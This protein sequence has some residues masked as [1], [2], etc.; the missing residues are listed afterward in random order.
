M[1]SDANFFWVTLYIVHGAARHSTALL[2]HEEI[3][4][5]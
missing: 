2:F 4:Q 5:V 1:F 3:Y